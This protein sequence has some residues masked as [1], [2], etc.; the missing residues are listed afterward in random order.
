MFSLLAASSGATD[1]GTTW[2]VSVFLSL[3]HQAQAG[4]SARCAF[5]AVLT[6]DSLRAP[7]VISD[8][9]LATYRINS[10]MI[11]SQGVVMVKKGI[12]DWIYDN[13]GYALFVLFVIWMIAGFLFGL[14]EPADSFPPF[15]TRWH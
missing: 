1:T 12:G 15:D 8:G 11:I 6:L 5:I 4:F 2:C 14:D 9:F 13:W 10:N 7:R 3:P